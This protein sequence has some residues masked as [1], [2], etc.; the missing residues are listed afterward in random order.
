MKTDDVAP[1]VPPPS[2]NP[3]KNP[4]EWI[5]KDEPM[6]GPQRSYLHTLPGRRRRIQSK[7]DQGRSLEKD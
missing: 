4:D 7:L 1:D 5:T 2:L 3:E 6:T